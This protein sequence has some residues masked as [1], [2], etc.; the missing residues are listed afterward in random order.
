MTFELKLER[1]EGASWIPR[2][3]DFLVEESWVHR[4]ERGDCT[5]I[6][7]NIKK[8]SESGVDEAGRGKGSKPEG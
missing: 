6:N 3:R 2:G 1:S 5:A 4:P 8:A 7:I